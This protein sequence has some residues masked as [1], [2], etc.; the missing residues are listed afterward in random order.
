[1]SI[2]IG[3]SRNI[4]LHA[5]DLYRLIIYPY[6]ADSQG[7]EFVAIITVEQRGNSVSGID[8]FDVTQA[9]SGRQKNGSNRNNPAA[10]NGGSQANTKFQGVNLIKTSSKISIRDLLGIVKDTYQSILSGDVLKHLGEERNPQGHYYDRVRYSVDDEENAIYME[11][12]ALGDMETAQ[13]LVDEA[14]KVFE[15]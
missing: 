5:V 6:A 2:I 10:S 11:A 13:R 4:Q 7:R 15:C 12:V 8:V 3:V 1:M 9:V 14:A